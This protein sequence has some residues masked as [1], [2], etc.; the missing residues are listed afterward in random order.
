LSQAVAHHFERTRRN[1]EPDI[2]RATLCDLLWKRTIAQ[3]YFQYIVAIKL[4]QPHL[5]EQMGVYSKY[6]ASKFSRDL[7]ELSV[8]PS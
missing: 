1:I 3:A 7:G 8:T 5:L 4:R 2:S 6:Q